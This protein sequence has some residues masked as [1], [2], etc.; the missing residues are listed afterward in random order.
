MRIAFVTETWRPT[1]NGV[2]TRIAMTVESLI[3]EGHEVLIVSPVVDR[4]VPV[5][6]ESPGLLVRRVPSFSF[7]FLYGGEPW[8]FRCRA[9]AAS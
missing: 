5:R 8:G 6:E 9:S 1:I 4:A 3:A 2:V 7:S